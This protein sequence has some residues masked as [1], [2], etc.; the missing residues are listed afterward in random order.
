MDLSWDQGRAMLVREV[1]DELP[2]REP[3]YTTVLTVLDRLAKKGLVRRDRD[4]RAWR[5]A[6]AAPREKY[7]ARLMLPRWT[8]LPTGMPRWRG[9]PTG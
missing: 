2:D 3:A 6:P 5:S 8:C 1:A 4:G 9:S 7:V